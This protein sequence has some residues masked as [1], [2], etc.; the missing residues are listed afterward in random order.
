[1]MWTRDF[2]CDFEIVATVRRRFRVYRQTN[3][4]NILLHTKPRVKYSELNVKLTGRCG[5]TVSCV[6]PLVAFIFGGGGLIKDF[7]KGGSATCLTIQKLRRWPELIPGRPR[8]IL[9]TFPNVSNRFHH[10]GPILNSDYWST[11]SPL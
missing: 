7:K 8:S 6:F 4:S 10:G 2:R 11:I 3:V 5:K 9:E 1:M